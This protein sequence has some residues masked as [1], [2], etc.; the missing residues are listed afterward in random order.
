MLSAKLTMFKTISVNCFD[1]ESCRKTQIN[2]LVSGHVAVASIWSQTASFTRSCFLS[3]A[4]Q[5]MTEAEEDKLLALKDFMLKS[6]KAKANMGEQSHLGE[7]THTGVID[8]A[9]LG[10]TGRQV[11][12]VK[13][14]AE[15]EDKRG[16][17][18]SLFGLIVRKTFVSVAEKL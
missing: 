17:Q 12:L 5:G 3:C 8:L 13:P 10:I 2:L 7:A 1:P 6:N 4:V 15:A 11:D 14:K 9:M 18:Q 16:N